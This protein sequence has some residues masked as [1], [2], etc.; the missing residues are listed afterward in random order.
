M[1]SITHSHC[2][3]RRK[4]PQ[5][6]IRHQGWQVRKVG[7]LDEKLPAHVLQENSSPETVKQAGCA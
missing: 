7:S 4:F 1:R 6:I 2:Q 3:Y 5:K